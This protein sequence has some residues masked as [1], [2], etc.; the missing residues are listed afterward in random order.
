MRLI[1]LS[2]IHANLSALRA[3]VKDFQTRYEPDALLLLGDL[4]NYGMRPN[5]VIEE[6]KKLSQFYPVLCNLYGNHEKAIVSPGEHLSR[7][8]SERGRQILEYTRHI[9]SSE[10]IAYIQDIME[11]FGHKLLQIDGRNVLCVHGS[12]NDPYWG[13]LDTA[14]VEDEG[15]AA[16]D[17]V[18]SGH[19]HLPHYIEILYKA[20]LPERRNKK[21]TI[22]LNPGSVG[23]PRN[24]NSG[25][26]YLYADL[27]ADIFH[28]NSVPYDI[29]TE[30]NLYRSEIDVFYRDRLSKGI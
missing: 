5:E 22:F 17:Y 2:D 12:P 4:V 24:Q 28:H 1:V 9:L 19:T 16:Y 23:Q 11:P 27:A 6:V 8:S 7:F 13:K 30:Q 18:F 26:Q 25:A 3:V 21:K 20:D 29:V 14:S 10:S 15:Y